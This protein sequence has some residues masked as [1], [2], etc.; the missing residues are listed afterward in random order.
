[1]PIYEYECEKCGENT[2]HIFSI[3]EKPETL[4][5]PICGGNAKSII[6]FMADRQAEW[7]PY[8]DD[9]LGDNPVLVEGRLHR[10]KLMKEN[11]L[12]D[13]YDVK[14]N[15]GAAFSLKGDR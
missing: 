2:D 6:S 9:N 8:W 5:C 7:S 4:E 12:S 15:G 14:R 13:Q 3:D 1:M 11:G 10:N